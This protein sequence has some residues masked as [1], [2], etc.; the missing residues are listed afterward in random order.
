MADQLAIIRAGCITPAAP[1]HTFYSH[2]LDPDMA[3]FVGA[4]NLLN[5]TIDGGHA[6]TRLGTLPIRGA[7]PNG[8]SSPSTAA[9]VLVRPEQIDVRIDAG[10]GDGRGGSI[11]G[12][13]IAGSVVECDYYGHDALVSI[14]PDGTDE[15]IVAR[16]EGARAPARDSRVTIHAHGTVIAWP[17]DR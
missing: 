13:G 16:V 2:P 11:G 5:G 8:S 15:L 10:G 1:P 14:R 3:T 12:A 7:N 6:T 4:A 17:A 9:I